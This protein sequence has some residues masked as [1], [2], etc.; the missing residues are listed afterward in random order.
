[1]A[2]PGALDFLEPALEQLRSQGLLR[3][4][5]PSSSRGALLDLCSND[6][7]GYGRDPWPAEAA[8]CTS[9]SGAARLVGEGRPEYEEAERTLADW[10]GYP[11]VL[12][13]SSGYA[14]NVG[15]M[16][17]LAT[18]DDLIVSDELNHASII[19]GCRL[20]RAEVL[21]TPHRD[22]AAVDQALRETSTKGRRWVVTESYFSMDGD[23][24]DLAQ[25]RAIC[26]RHGAGL[27]V[28]EAHALGVFGPSGRGRCAELGVRPDVLVGAAGKALGLQGAFVAGSE[29]LRTWLW[30]RA[31]SFVFSTGMSPALARAL[32]IRVARLA[33]DEGGRETLWRNVRDL[34]SRLSK[35]GAH[36][37]E[38]QVGPIL[39]WIVG[40]PEE[41]MGLSKA[42]A[43]HGVR[44]RAI[45]PPTVPK[46]TARLR[47]TAT[48]AL[49][50][51]DL[52]RA[53]QAFASALGKEAAR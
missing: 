16:T 15:V 26:D 34:R 13:F 38:A 53:V 28:D 10:L 33:A 6:Y 52:E 8:G 37:P 44:V 48:A 41:A 24:P 36:W 29:S 21:V 17:A 39:T 11:S 14:A 3:D 43:D 45:R 30:N 42:L 25:L 31:R 5:R 20:S 18:R 1:M 4:P 22:A 7:L 40:S 49:T 23:S 50:P 46:G 32:E 47:I 12:L 19:D 2:H 27:I 9:G 35:L 51:A